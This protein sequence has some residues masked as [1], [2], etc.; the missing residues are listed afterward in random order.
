MVVTLVQGPYAG[1]VASDDWKSRRWY[2][3]LRGVMLH[4]DIRKCVGRFRLQLS[5]EHSEGILILFGRSGAGKTTALR[6]IAGMDKPTEGVIS[7][8]NR[9]LFSSEK[10]VNVSIQNR[11]IGFIFQEHNLFPHMTAYQN[12]AYAAKVRAEIDKWLQVFHVSDLTDRYPSRLSGG[13][14]QRIAIIRALVS[15][16]KLLLMDEP[17]SAVDVATRTVL[18]DELRALPRSNG[19]PIIYVTHNVSEAYR[20][21]DRVLVLE[22]GNVIHDGVPI[23]VFHAPTSVPL[24]SLSGTENILN[25][26]VIAH[27]TDDNTTELRV[28]QTILHVP[29]CREK[30]GRTAVVAVRP[31]DI[32]IAMH[33]LADTSARN[34]LRGR[35][36]EVLDERLPLVKVEVSGGP[37]LLVRVTRRSLQTLGLR[38]GVVVYLLIKAWAFHP[39]EAD[40]SLPAELATVRKSAD[41]QGHGRP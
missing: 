33:E 36:V 29:L 25:S 2:I 23:E 16:P 8:D 1:Y 11:S 3:K 38:K 31:E 6:A 28:G 26:V 40:S 17:L 37:T 35:V 9:T 34:Q 18:L 30:V 39:I 21:G 41:K 7:F 22:E 15:R 19:I 20:L 5:F 14:Q 27:L 13:E 12:I 24:A 10:R 4:V 32:L